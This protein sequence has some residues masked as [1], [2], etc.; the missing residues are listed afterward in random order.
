MITIE[1]NKVCYLLDVDG[2]LTEH[3]QQIS[4]SFANEFILWSMQKQCFIATGSDFE[5]T[6]QQVPWDILDCF[7]NIFCCMGNEVRNNLGQ[8]L[9]KSDFKTI[10]VKKSCQT[11]KRV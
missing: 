9:K 4:D 8:I 7:E 6:K 1:P 10:C 2:T 5:K 11:E 3:R